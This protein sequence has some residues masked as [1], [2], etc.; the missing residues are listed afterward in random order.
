MRTPKL[1]TNLRH[2][3]DECWSML[4]RSTT[5]LGRGRPHDALWTQSP[6][7]ISIWNRVGGDARGFRQDLRGGI[8]RRSD[9]L[10]ARCC[11]RPYRTMTRATLPRQL[12]S[13][14]IERTLMQG[15]ARLCSSPFVRLRE[16]PAGPPEDWDG[17]LP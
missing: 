10:F 2:K 7:K 14:K 9:A 5:R 17:G 12:G 8:D 13:K 4:W 3:G 15:T 11:R 16:A 1:A 6:G